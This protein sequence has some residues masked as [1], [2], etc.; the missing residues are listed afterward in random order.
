MKLGCLGS[1]PPDPRVMGLAGLTQ[2][3]TQPHTQPLKTLG[4]QGTARTLSCSSLLAEEIL[5]GETESRELGVLEAP[6]PC[7]LRKGEGLVVSPPPQDSGHTCC[8]QQREG[9]AHGQAQ[10]LVSVRL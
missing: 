5:Q 2:L 8:S 9:D 7:P 6:S 1:F 4:A 10:V 3:E